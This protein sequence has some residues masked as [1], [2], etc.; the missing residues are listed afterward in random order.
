MGLQWRTPALGMLSVS[1]LDGII[2]RRRSVLLTYVITLAG[3]GFLWLLRIEPSVWMLGGFVV[4]CGATLGSRS[5]LISATA[6]QL[7]RGR[8]SA[9]IFG[10]TSIGAGADQAIGAWIGGLL[11]DWTGGY[12]AMM[13]GPTRDRGRFPTHIKPCCAGGSFPI[14][15]TTSH[16]GT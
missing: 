13:N 6:V 9:T 3:L 4:C 16:E 8:A 5:P 1:S 10:S 7:F 11:H 2:G 12:D 15:V 14:C